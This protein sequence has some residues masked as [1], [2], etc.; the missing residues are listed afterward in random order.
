M[1]C[2]ERTARDRADHIVPPPSAT[3]RPTSEPPRAPRLVIAVLALLAATLAGILASSP[4]DV[5]RWLVLLPFAGLAFNVALVARLGTGV[6]AARAETIKW[7]YLL[8]AIVGG[9]LLVLLIERNAV[10]QKAA[11]AAFS[12][13]LSFRAGRELLAHATVPDALGL[14]T[15]LT[16]YAALAHGALLAAT[17]AFASWPGVHP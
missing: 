17:L 3:R 11:L 8:L 9:G 1:F 13:I 4:G 14:A 5:R 10:P 6:S 16:H 7:L 12:L 2:S 15:R